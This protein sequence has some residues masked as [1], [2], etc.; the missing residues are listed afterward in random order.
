MKIMTQTRKQAIANGD[1]VYNTGKPCKHGHYSNR[2]TATG[3][4]IECERIAQRTPARRQYNRDKIKS[5][6]YKKQREEYRRTVM[7]T[8]KYKLWARATH[9]NRAYGLTIDQFN[10]LYET[11]GSC[12]AICQ[13]KL[14]DNEKCVDHC[15]TTG[16]VRGVV[17]DSCNKLLG[18]ARDDITILQSAIKYLEQT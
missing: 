15:H 16:D 13:S 7:G 9:L 12:C 6:K 5:D 10:E 14:E 11:Q 2:R 8:D 4:C 18:F 3:V 17:C 1:I